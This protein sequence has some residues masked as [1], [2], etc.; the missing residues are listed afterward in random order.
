M[1]YPRLSLARQLLQDDG[2][3]VISIDD[4]E[5]SNLRRLMDDVFGEDGFVA[6]FVWKS[7]KFP[8]SRNT[9]QVSVD[10]E[11][12]VVYRRSIEGQF[13]GVERDETKFQ[14]PDNDARGPWMSRSILGLATAQQRPNLHY[15]ITDPTT[16]L[17][18]DP[19]ADRGWRYGKVRMQK[20]IE[21]GCILF[22]A[23]PDGR[24]REK[25]FQKDLKTAFMA[26]PSIIDDVHTSDGTEEIREAFGFL[27]FDFSKPSHLIRKFIEQLTGDD[28]AIIDFFAGSGATAQAVIDQNRHDGQR[29]RSICV[30]LPA[31]THKDSEAAKRGYPTIADISR[32]RVR[33]SIS[34]GAKT[35]A[36]TDQ[37]DL[38]NGQDVGFRAFKLAASSVLG[39]KGVADKSP[40]AYATQLEAFADTL[41]P[42]WKPENVIWE[43]ALREGFSLTSRIEKLSAPKSGTF[44]RVIDPEQDRAFTICL[45]ATLT[46]D[47]VR[48]LNLSKDHLFICR[49]AALDDTLA[50]NLALQCRLKVI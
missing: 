33:S 48:G 49:D 42:G 9:T 43:V 13:R 2:F 40:D 5:Q 35:E 30:Q 8:D 22:P 14:N 28:D 32:Y 4:V 18:F 38:S 46:L 20:L 17:I 45:D 44:W 37:I 26:M 36:A 7:R 41:V 3:L 50:A 27:A 6:Q 47:S 16:G 15:L 39:W 34:R 23:R 1:M 10:H 11:Y 19:P 24:P 12:I 25:K 31:R 21:D 29:R